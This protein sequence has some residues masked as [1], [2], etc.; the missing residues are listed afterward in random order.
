VSRPA[1][2]ESVLPAEPFKR[3]GPSDR[4][5]GRPLWPPVQRR[6]ARR[7]NPVGF[8]VA[9]VG[10]GDPLALPLRPRASRRD[11]FRRPGKSSGP[12]PFAPSLNVQG[13]D[14]HHNSGFDALNRQTASQGRAHGE[15]HNCVPNKDGADFPPLLQSDHTIAVVQGLPG[16]HERICAIQLTSVRPGP[17]RCVLRCVSCVEC[18]K[19]MASCNRTAAASFTFENS[20]DWADRKPT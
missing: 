14:T 8:S 7:F 1:Q 4:C 18:R 5:A 3:S 19:L 16:A 12:P 9:R 10:S 6:G 17:R 13:D 11:R 15:G 2:V 20:F